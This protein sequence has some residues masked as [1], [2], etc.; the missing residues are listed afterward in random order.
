MSRAVCT[1]E[2]E[3]CGHCNPIRLT[4]RWLHSATCPVAVNLLRDAASDRAW[5]AWHP[6]LGTR[7]RAVTWAESVLVRRALVALRR[8][9]D[10]H[11]LNTEGLAVVVTR[12]GDSQVRRFTGEALVLSDSS[13]DEVPLPR[14]VQVRDER[15][16]TNVLT[17]A[18]A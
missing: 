14:S 1:C 7:T 18:V 12:R 6:H 11:T 2:A 3:P 9:S 8:A 13:G 17:G 4:D 15:P 10:E 5:F 16:A